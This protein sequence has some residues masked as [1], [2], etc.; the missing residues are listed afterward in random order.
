MAITTSESINK[1]KKISESDPK[2]PSGKTAAAR[3]NAA[4][5]DQKAEMKDESAVPKRVGDKAEP[6][7]YV[8]T[9][10]SGGNERPEGDLDDGDTRKYLAKQEKVKVYIPRARGTQTVQINVGSDPTFIAFLVAAIGALAAFSAWLIKDTISD[11]RKQRDA[12]TTGWQGQVTVTDKL[13]DALA[14]RNAIDER[15]VAMLKEA[16]R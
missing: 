3:E 5:S 10:E 11:S 1:N 4:R 2:D 7:P 14:E 9:T 8:E 6:Q 12:A 13:A 15:M 16:M